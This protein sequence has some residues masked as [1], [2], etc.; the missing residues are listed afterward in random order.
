MRTV[1]WQEVSRSLNDI[2]RQSHPTNL[3]T[4]ALFY[5][6]ETTYFHPLCFRL[7]LFSPALI[8]RVKSCY[9]KCTEWGKPQAAA[10]GVD[11][12]ILSSGRVAFCDIGTKETS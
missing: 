12:L 11:L 8:S 9:C 10:V 2:I 5:E 6:R 1:I 4:L 3:D 7:S